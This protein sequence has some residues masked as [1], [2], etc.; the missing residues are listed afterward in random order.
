MPNPIFNRFNQSNPSP[1]PFS[2]VQNMVNQFNQFR[3]QF[4]GDPKAQVQQLLDSG[5]MT[6]E[7]F[8]QLSNLANQFQSM[9]R[10]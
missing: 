4:Q 9:M 3:A 5:K 10:R 2:N 1:G 6:Q 7:Q 8:N